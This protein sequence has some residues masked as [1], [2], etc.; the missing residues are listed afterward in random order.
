MIIST[1]R[2]IMKLYVL[3]FIAVF[4]ACAGGKDASKTNMADSKTEEEWAIDGYTAGTIQDFSLLDGC[5]FLIVMNDAQLL[6]INLAEEFKK[7]N[8]AVWVKYHYPKAAQTTCMKGKPIL[9]DE[10][11]L[12]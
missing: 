2:V 8:L 7:N 3:I 10:I 6:P 11:K 1:T 4:S 9:I 12:R 5:G